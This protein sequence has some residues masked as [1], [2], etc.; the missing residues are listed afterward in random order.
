MPARRRLEVAAPGSEPLEACRRC[1]TEFPESTLDDGRW[2]PQCHGALESAAARGQHAIAALVTLP[3]AVWI[4][5]E[6]TRGYFPV[7]AW[8]IP[9]AAAYY[10]GM[11]IGREVVRGWYRSRDRS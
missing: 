7:Y 10:L 2:C 1:G 3:F 11:R 5:I 9:L 6:G 4:F 8:A